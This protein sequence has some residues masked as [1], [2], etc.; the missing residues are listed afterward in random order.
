MVL[1]ISLFRLCRRS[2]RIFSIFWGFLW[3]ERCLILFSVLAFAC[4]AV[5]SFLQSLRACEHPRTMGRTCNP[6][7]GGLHTP[8]C[9]LSFAW[10]GSPCVQYGWGNPILNRESLI[11]NPQFCTFSILSHNFNNFNPTS[12]APER[13]QIHTDAAT[14]ATEAAPAIHFAAACVA[15][16]QRL[17]G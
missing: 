1:R 11:V 5:W 4:H 9:I 17:R 3:F 16:I 12:F 8:P 2:C 6:W 15:I 10:R 7:G 14:A 13:F